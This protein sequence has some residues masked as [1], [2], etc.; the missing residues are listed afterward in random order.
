M[1]AATEGRDS[2]DGRR[3]GER[4]C[5]GKDEDRRVSVVRQSSYK[6]LVISI[7]CQ[8]EEKKR[9]TSVEQTTG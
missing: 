1:A 8:M 5:E 2:D 7:E 9:E 6:Q 3:D 4:Q